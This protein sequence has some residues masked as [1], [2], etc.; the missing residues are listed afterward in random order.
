[1]NIA[2]ELN[3]TLVQ[4]SNGNY[5]M[6]VLGTTGDTPKQEVWQSKLRKSIDTT[7]NQL[8]VVSTS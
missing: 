5:A 4:D 2:T 3:K 6:Q 1:M 7:S 8:R